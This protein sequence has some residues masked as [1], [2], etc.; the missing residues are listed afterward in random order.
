MEGV[1]GGLRRKSEIAEVYGSARRPSTLSTNATTLISK[2][3][4]ARSGSLLRED[5][6]SPTENSSL[7]G[8]VLESS[9]TAGSTDNGDDGVSFLAEIPAIIVTLMIN[10]MTAIPFGVAYFPLGWSSDS[11]DGEDDGDGSISGPFPLP[12]KEVLG[13]RMFLFAC[14][15]GQ[16]VLALAS[17][18][19]SPVSVQLIENVPFYHALAGIVIAEQGYGKEALSTLF[20]LFGLSSIVTGL[21]FYGL[22][23]AGLGKVVYYFPSHVL[24]GFIGGIGVFIAV[25]STGVMTGE[26]FEF[27]LEGVGTLMANFQEFAPALAFE[28]ILRILMTVLKDKEGKQIFNLLAPVYFIS[29]VPLFYIALYLLGIGMDDATDRGYFFPAASSPS[30]LTEDGLLTKDPSFLDG[31]FDG[32]ILDMFRTIDLRTVSWAAVGKS[33]GT[34]FGMSCFSVINVPINIPAFANAC[35]VDVD[36]N[37][38]L[39]AHGYSNILAGLFGGIQNVMTYSVSVLFYNSGG[40]EQGRAICIGHRYD[41]CLCV[42]GFHHAL[43]SKVYGGDIVATHWCVFVYRRRFRFHRGERQD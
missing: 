1:V 22:G 32:H 33:L 4:W 29:I 20:F 30:E 3:E 42:W 31:I 5:E 41:H 28:I 13:I 35:D 11:G 17:K 18:F 37:N 38:E 6:G 10:F 26:D 27:T 7:L 43:Y 9:S 14:I 39:L 2:A 12:G 25:S 23:K 15:T 24:V 34:V 40:G 21:M 16:I 36:M 19:G 8:N